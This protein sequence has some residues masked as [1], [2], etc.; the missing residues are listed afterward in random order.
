MTFISPTADTEWVPVPI[1]PVRIPGP[2]RREMERARR[3]VEKECRVCF[4][5]IGWYQRRKWLGAAPYAGPRARPV[6]FRRLTVGQFEEDVSVLWLDADASDAKNLEQIC[7]T[8]R[9]AWIATHAADAFRRTGR[10][11]RQRDVVLWTAERLGA[12]KAFLATPPEP[13][14]TSIKAGSNGW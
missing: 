10:R 1:D 4:L 3:W 9:A 12:L 11:A 8:A 13:D 14:Y 5:E 2:R 6:D 7:D